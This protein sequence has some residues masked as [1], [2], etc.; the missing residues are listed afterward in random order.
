ADW[1]MRHFKYR[2]EAS[3]GYLHDYGIDAWTNAV[4]YIGMEKWAN[5][6]GD[7]ACYQ[8]LYNIGMESKW[9]LAENFIQ[10]PSYGIYHAD[11]LCMGQFYLAMA[12]DFPNQPEI[13]KNTQTRIESILSNP[14]HPEIHVNNK[15]VWSWCDA[16]FM[17]PPVYSRLT[18]LTGDEKYLRF[19]DQQFRASYQHLYDPE[20]HLFFRD[21]SFFDQR[22]A[23]GKKIF[24]GRGNGWVAA[25]VVNILKTLPENS[26][27]RP[28]YENLLKELVIRLASLQDPSG[29]WHAS[30]LD[31]DSYPSPETSA[32]A[33]I[34]YAIAYGINQNLLDKKE[35]EPV[36][37][38]SW[39]ALS[40]AVDSEGKLGWVQAIGANPKKATADMT[41]VYGIGA[42]LMAGSEICFLIN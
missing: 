11:E 34:T 42:F 25:G 36:V 15:Q 29:F 10:I 31:P 7:S 21:S 1:Q 23:N 24:W 13:Y 30:L 16:L 26:P 19:M 41:A 32:S 38:K 27:Y 18:Q 8:W 3:P 4:L 6:S 28:F 40:S 14:P 33:L 20:E 5:L 39:K 2:K 35:F 17:A 12:E 9:K 37:K 22:E